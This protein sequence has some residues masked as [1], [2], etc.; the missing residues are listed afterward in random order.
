[1]VSR[2]I[3][4]PVLSCTEVQ[5]VFIISCSLV[6][7]PKLSILLLDE[8]DLVLFNR[9]SIWAFVRVSVYLLTMRPSASYCY[10]SSLSF[11]CT[12]MFSNILADS[13]SSVF[14]SPSSS[15]VLTYT[16]KINPIRIISDPYRYTTSEWNLPL[17]RISPNLR[18]TY[19]RR[20]YTKKPSTK[21]R[22]QATL[23]KL[24]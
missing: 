23:H 18:V 2:S 15:K 1:M 4:P 13:S 8:V 7:N 11:A 10:V 22:I 5:I 14:C 20:R 21:I 6:L 17:W 12:H 19:H 16:T 24:P 9:P 3:Y